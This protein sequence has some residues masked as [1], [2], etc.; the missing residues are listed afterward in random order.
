MWIDGWVAVSCVGIRFTGENTDE[1]LSQYLQASG[2]LGVAAS[3]SHLLEG[4]RT[5]G[6][7]VTMRCGSQKALRKPSLGLELQLTLLRHLLSFWAV[8]FQG[9]WQKIVPVILLAF[10]CICYN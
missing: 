10:A 9:V 8:D 1:F 3:L 7:M 2:Y 5:Q 4:I 6:V